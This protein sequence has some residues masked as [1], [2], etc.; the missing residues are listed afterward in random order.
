[1]ITKVSTW[2]FGHKVWFRQFDNPFVVF[3]ASV[4]RVLGL[5]GTE[6]MYEVAKVD[7]GIS[8]KRVAIES[9]LS[10]ASQDPIFTY[11]EK[12]FY[13]EATGTYK[14]RSG[15]VCSATFATRPA[16]TPEPRRVEEPGPNNSKTDSSSPVQSDKQR[17]PRV[18][19]VPVPVERSE[20]SE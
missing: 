15:G 18:R 6:V 8:V 4:L 7:R 5:N 12:G 16:G 1:M 17:K 11:R 9:Q 10:D 2:K 14:L 20:S 3:P 19:E 13:D